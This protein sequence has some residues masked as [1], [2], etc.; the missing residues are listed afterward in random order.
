MSRQTFVSRCLVLVLIA[1]GATASFERAEAGTKKR[2]GYAL[3]VGVRN[4]EHRSLAELKYTE[5]DVEKLARLLDRAGSPYHSRV[6]VLS[7]TRGQKDKAD[8]P[9]AENVR[10]ALAALVK[11]RTRHDTVLLALSGH[12]VQLQVKCPSG[13]KPE[14]TFPYFCPVDAQLAGADYET[15]RHPRL[16]HLQEVMSKLGECGAGAKLV[17]VDACRNELQARSSTR[18]L[19]LKSEMVPEGVAALFSCKTG[20]VSFEVEQL[21]HGLFF[22]FVL[23]GLAGRAKNTR[24]EV[25]WGGLAEYVTRQVTRQAGKLAGHGARQTPQEVKNLEGES[26]LLLRSAPAG[27]PAA[28]TAPP[29]DEKP[30]REVFKGKAFTNTLGMKLMPIPAG[31]FVRGSPTNEKGRGSDE[32]PLLRVEIAR[33]FYLGAYEVTQVQFRNV[34]GYNPSYFTPGGEKGDLVKGLDTSDFPVERVTWNE[35]AAF[36]R[37]LSALPAEK[38][39]GRVYRL[40][41][42]AE[43]EYACRA[44]GRGPRPFNHGISLSSRLA[45]IDARYPYGG[46]KRRQPLGRT[47]RV[48]S[49]KPN[50]WGLYDMHGNVQ[51]WCADRYGEPDVQNSLKKSVRSAGDDL[52]RRVLRGGSWAR[53]AVGARSAARAWGPPNYRYS[54]NGF[55]V[56]C[57]VKGR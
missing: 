15:G 19:S 55:R 18:A 28:T 32:G 13:E 24:G 34:M 47:T 40:P 1:L 39:A 45:N 8:R 53:P 49:Y 3:L 26:P 5:N 44:G 30:A 27:E 29:V 35:A 2:H 56:V 41:T 11:D 57:V 20:Q 12:G 10:N 21:R 38:A 52:E 23:R 43:W 48:G 36:C 22:H 4:Y 7:C 6:R 51:E 14:K 31:S 42:E 9:T 17:L 46:G 37:K 33:P 50:A 25:T 54:E 16:I